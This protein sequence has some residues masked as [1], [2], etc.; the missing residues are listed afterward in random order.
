MVYFHGWRGRRH[1]RTAPPA[2]AGRGLSR[3]CTRHHLQE[4]RMSTAVDREVARWCFGWQWRQDW[5]AWCP[6][7]WPSYEIIDPPYTTW[8]EPLAAH[9]GIPWGHSVFGSRDTYGRPRI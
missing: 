4:G 1:A 8:A 5:Q 7:G 3:E 9:G 6:P 2:P